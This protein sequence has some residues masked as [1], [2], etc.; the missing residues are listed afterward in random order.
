[1]EQ[2]SV[3]TTKIYIKENKE[4]NWGKQRVQYQEWVDPSS[5]SR[6]P[7]RFCLGVWMKG[8]RRDLNGG[9]K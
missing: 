3:A 5:K 8:E 9:R 6:G 2:L 4:K 1:V 7:L